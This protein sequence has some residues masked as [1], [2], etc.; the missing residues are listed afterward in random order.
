MWPP[1]FPWQEK[2]RSRRNG[3]SEVQNKGNSLLPFTFLFPR[4]QSHVHNPTATDAGL[5][6]TVHEY[7]MSIIYLCNT[8]NYR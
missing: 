8:D 1:T 5:Y 4:T 6:R 2:E 3:F 7:L